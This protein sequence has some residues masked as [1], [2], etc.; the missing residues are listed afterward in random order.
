MDELLP[1]DH[2]EEIAIFRS[3]VIGSVVHRQLTRGELRGALRELARQKFRPPAAERTRH[4]SVPTL[5][6][7]YCRFRKHGLAS[8]RR[9]G[10][11]RFGGQA[12]ARVI[13]GRPP[14]HAPGTPG[15]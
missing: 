1:K 9:A 7:W 11:P 5:E 4:F 3:Q 6:R 2:G 10:R 8:L 13:G 14:R 12:R 15:V